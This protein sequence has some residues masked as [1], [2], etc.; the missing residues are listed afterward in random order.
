MITDLFIK[1]DVNNQNS[2]EIVYNINENLI[3]LKVEI[4]SID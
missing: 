1:S 4:F 3:I 2:T